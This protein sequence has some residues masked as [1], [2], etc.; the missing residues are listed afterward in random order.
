METDLN[1]ISLTG[2]L[3]SFNTINPPGNE[4]DCAKYLG[5]L[6]EAVGFKTMYFEFD[7]GRTS[8]IARMQG[9]T[10]RTPLCFAGHIDTVP[11]GASPWN[12]DPHSGEIS[13]DKI[14]G[15][16]STDMKAGIAAMVIMAQRLSKISKGTAALT[17]V[18]TAGEETSCEGAYH[19]AKAGKA[20]GEAGALV[21]GEP[22]AN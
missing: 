18:F 16:G 12:I 17:L 9:T 1:P 15:R 22:T 19:L 4:R 10:H 3:I 5:K 21:V 13:G 20:L 14:Y 2:K 6:L 7:I 8:L 11:L